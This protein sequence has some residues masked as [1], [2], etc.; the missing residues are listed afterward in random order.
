MMNQNQEKKLLTIDY[1]R[2]SL[3]LCHVYL[4]D[5]EGK[6]IECNDLQAKSFGLDRGNEVVGYQ[7]KDFFCQKDLT[8]ICNNDLEVL[9]SEIPKLFMESVIFADQIYR[10][11]LSIKLPFRSITGKL[12]GVFGISIPLHND[13][14]CFSCGTEKS[15]LNLNPEGM[16]E[17]GNKKISKR[18]KECMHYLSQGMTAKKIASI[19]MLSPRTI[20]FYIENIKKKFNCKNRTEL[21]AKVICTAGSYT[22]LMT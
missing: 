7:D 2:C 10:P 22:D 12:I 15:K 1:T 17:V 20:E 5:K 6:Y 11:I 3:L 18:E 9:Y 4:K 14:I 21:I 19:L 16:R 8:M 13:D